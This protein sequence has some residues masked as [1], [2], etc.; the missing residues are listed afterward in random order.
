MLVGVSIVS[1]YNVVFVSSSSFFSCF[2]SNPFI[3]SFVIFSFSFVFSFSVIVFSSGKRFIARI[4]SIV[5]SSL[6]IGVMSFIII[7]PLFCGSA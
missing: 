5:F 7:S 3:V 2:T 1:V 4:C 6:V